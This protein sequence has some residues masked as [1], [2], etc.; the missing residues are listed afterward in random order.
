MIKLEIKNLKSITQV[1]VELPFEEGVFAITGENGVGKSTIFAALSKLV[2]R[3]ALR[4]FFKYEGDADTFIKFTYNGQTNTWNRRLNWQR[5]DTDPEI[6][7]DGTFEASLIFGSRFANFEKSKVWRGNVLTESDFVDADPFVKENLGEILRGD[8]NFYQNLQIIRSLALAKR[9]EFEGRPYFFEVKNKRLP[10]FAMSSGE[11]LLVGLLH[12]IN[13]R[14]EYKQRRQ[15]KD[16]SLILIDEIELALHPSA[17]KRLVVFLEKI[18]TEDGFCIYFAT[19]SIQIINSIVPARMFHFQK[20]ALNE[21][22]VINPCYPAYATRSLYTNDGF[23]F[24]FLVEDSLTKYILEEIINELKLYD[25]KLMKI[26]PSGGWRQTLEMHYQISLSGI[27]GKTCKIF[28]ILDG[29]IEQDYNREQTPKYCNL[30]KTFLPMNSVEKYLKLHLVDQPNPSFT[31]IL[32]DRI[33]TQRDLKNIICDYR[34]KLVNDNNGKKLYRHLKDEALK[35]GFT[36]DSFDASLC[37]IIYE[38]VDFSAMKAT[39][40]RITKASN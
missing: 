30:P 22:E 28:S 15:I 38:I 23:D 37:K 24:L 8:K 33:Y 31:R 9:C 36:V 11:L 4:S 17:Q 40:L 18:S 27:A 26:L 32:G 20:N 39:L 16:K 19:H 21:I 35:Q 13:D 1:V 7:F 34:S 29:D 5:I 14:R 12:F 2:Y 10:Q 25:S 3:G 6:F